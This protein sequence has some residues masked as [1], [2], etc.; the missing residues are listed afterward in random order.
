MVSP[1]TPSVTPEEDSKMWFDYPSCWAVPLCFLASGII[2]LGPSAYFF[3]ISPFCFIILLL[4][5]NYL[6][7]LLNP[8]EVKEVPARGYGFR[9]ESHSS[10]LTGHL[11]NSQ[12]ISCMMA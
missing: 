1:E 6:Q 11:K 8:Q 3:A 4:V 7:N 5:S 10:Q 12:T 9:S 2:F